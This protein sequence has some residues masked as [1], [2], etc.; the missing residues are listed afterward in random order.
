MVKQT[1]TISINFTGGIISPGYLLSVLEIA[2]A[3][4][5][6]EVRFSLRQQ[7]LL[8]VPVKYLDEFEESC[9][10]R[11]IVCH[12]YGAVPNITS[13]YPGAGIFIADSWLSE[14][15]YKDVFDMFDYMPALK[16][17][18]CD[19][20]QTFTPFFSGHINWIAAGPAHYWHLFIR[21]PKSSR[22][23]AW[24]SLVYTNNIGQL[25]Y[26][27]E[28]ILAAN[29]NISNENLYALVKEKLD[30]A[31][32]NLSSEL[33]LPPFHLPYYEGF[34]KDNNSWW[35][36]IYRR[37]EGFPVPFLINLCTICLETK[38]GQLYVTSWKS[39]IIR[40]IAP[41]HRKLWDYLLGKYG[42]NVRHAANELNW[43][44]EDNNEDGLVI[45][46]HIIRHF[47]SADVRTY[48]LCFGVRMNPGSNH[49]GSIVISKQES[50]NKSRL[51]GLQRYDI[52]YTA[53]FNPNSGNLVPYRTGVAKEHLGPYITSLCRH[54][55]ESNATTDPLLHYVAGKQAVTGAAP[56]GRQIHQCPHCFT[57]YDEATGDP[58]QDVPAG[59]PFPELPSSYSCSLCGAPA[60]GFIV[61]N[62]ASLGWLADAQD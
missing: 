10:L 35:L 19:S 44:V 18:I 60:A 36:G 33:E 20:R 47:D 28:S 9:S 16:V 11:K 29:E 1:Q 53:D 48:G 34:N 4:R 59:T 42:I 15:I 54:F 30:Y 45:K 12:P 38:T 22:L 2:A 51:K 14:G 49:F 8:E 39:L 24:P 52:L 58:E 32:S 31:D 55:Y 25:S 62:T 61:T 7:L 37:D 40:H 57:V 3:A 26:C 17:N 6:T 43:L 27:I 21:F 23:F 56:T 50:K 41:A 13:S 5:V 46:R